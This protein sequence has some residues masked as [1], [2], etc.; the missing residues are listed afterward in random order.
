MKTHA[1]HSKGNMRKGEMIEKIVRRASEKKEIILKNSKFCNKQFG[2][3]IQLENC[4]V[5]V[6]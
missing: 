5:K 4:L 6:R 2:M 1:F 3:E